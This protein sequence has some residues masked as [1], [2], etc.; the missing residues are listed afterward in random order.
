MWCVCAFEYM[1]MYFSI[2]LSTHLPLN[3]KEAISLLICN[4]VFFPSDIDFLLFCCSV[5]VCSFNRVRSVCSFIRLSSLHSLSH[6]LMPFRF[7]LIFFSFHSFFIHSCTFFHRAQIRLVEFHYLKPTDDL[8]S[9]SCCVLKFCFFCFGVCVCVCVCVALIL[10][11][12]TLCYVLHFNLLILFISFTRIFQ[13]SF[14]SCF[15]FLSMLFSSL[16][17]ERWFS[18]KDWNF[19][20]F[21]WDNRQRPRLRTTATATTTTAPSKINKATWFFLDQFILWVRRLNAFIEN[22]IEIIIAFFYYVQRWQGKSEIN[23]SK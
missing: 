4:L 7:A 3:D 8:P 20:E 13:I 11:H 9:I 19:I 10:L 2:S 17:L 12:V 22:E 21:H 14:C 1:C 15:F 23:S 6:S 18:R 16:I 5:L